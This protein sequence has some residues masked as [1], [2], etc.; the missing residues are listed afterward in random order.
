[1]RG[2][3]ERL[4]GY[5]AAEHHAVGSQLPGAGRL[6]GVELSSQ[7]QRTDGEAHEADFF[8]GEFGHVCLVGGYLTGRVELLKESLGIV[9]FPE[10]KRPTA[11][12]EWKRHR[13]LNDEPMISNIPRRFR[14]LDA[15]D[16]YGDS[17]N[18]SVKRVW[19]ACRNDWDFDIPGF[20]QPACRVPLGKV[21]FLAGVDQDRPAEFC[22]PGTILNV[23]DS[24]YN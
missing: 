15:I 11:C 5:R 18:P 23:L 12:E 16:D 17:D 10:S 21:F 24:V 3:A 19:A 6:M 1:M 20:D 8:S 9:A 22:R 4:L 2:A 13:V 7:A 14:R